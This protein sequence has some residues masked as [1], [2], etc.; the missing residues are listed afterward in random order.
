M[1]TEQE[2]QNVGQHIC[3]IQRF[4]SI[5]FSRWAGT[6]MNRKK[7]C[8]W[9]LERLQIHCVVFSWLLNFFLCPSGGTLTPHPEMIPVSVITRDVCSLLEYSYF[10]QFLRQ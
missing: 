8:S 1:Y 2:H 3:S 5:A 7:G 4:S 6:A 10:S 9:E